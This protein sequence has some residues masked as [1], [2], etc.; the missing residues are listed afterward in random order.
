M[1]MQVYT[2]Y[3]LQKHNTMGIAATAATFLVLE[4]ID[5]IPHALE[6]YGA[7]AYVL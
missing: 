4:K 6:H 5:E 7:P 2:K 1:D 3:D